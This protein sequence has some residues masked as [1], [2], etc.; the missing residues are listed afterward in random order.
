MGTTGKKTL[1]FAFILLTACS[2]LVP[3]PDALRLMCGF[4]QTFIL[5]GLVLLFFIGD[6]KRPWTD[7]IFFVPLLSPILITLTVYILSRLTGE[8]GASPGY[9]AGLF[10]IL[11]AVAVALKQDRYG[12]GGGTLPGGVIILSVCYG[13]LISLLFFANDILLIRS[14]AWY[15]ASVTGE[16][17]AR[18]IPPQEPYLA[19][20]PI[21][22]MWIYHLFTATLIK[23]TGL[24]LFRALSMLNI[25]SALSLPYLA[26]RV[27]SHFTV[28]RRVIFVSTLI[29][30]AGLESASWIA[31]PLCFLRA[32]NGDVRG[33]EEI[34]R[35]IHDISF[36]GS[37]TI[38]TLSPFGTWMVNLSDKYITITPF[39]FSLDL[40]LL[41]FVM[42]LSGNYVTD[43]KLKSGVMFFIIALGAFLFHVITGAALICTIIGAGV[44]LPLI[45]KF[46][47]G[48]AGSVSAGSSVSSSAH[49]FAGLPAAVAALAAGLVGLPYFLSLQ[50]SGEN[51]AMSGILHF[52]FKNIATILLPLLILYCPAKRALKK[53]VSARIDAYAVIAAWF[54]PLLLLNIFANLPTRNESKLIYPLFLLIG[55]VVSIEIVALISESQRRKR[56]LL[57]AWTLLLFFIPPFLTF[58]G[59]LIARPQHLE[60]L[61]VRYAA[62]KS[63]KALYRWIEENTG[64]DAVVS[65]NGFDHL[66][67]AFAARRNFAG[68]MSHWRIYGYDKEYISKYFDLNTELYTCRPLT[69]ETAA[70]IRATGHDL[71]VCVYEN[72]LKECPALTAKFGDRPDLFELV[73]S[74][75]HALLYHLKPA[76]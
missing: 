59:Y 76:G 67:P 55:S 14:D 71:Y 23:L 1:F 64:T 47:S 74:D 15:H 9:A 61:D 37:G 73:Y 4:V 39:S 65:E 42:A 57:I 2:L 16:I 41:G 60:F 21:Q 68:P 53:V 20:Q 7:T 58:R 52:G 38:R 56:F 25:V 75:A 22:Y 31:W 69:D 46:R 5:P 54:I 66:M 34:M 45:K 43:S 44:M 29:T 24:P 12:E 49:S 10:Y 62:Y 63:D 18:G 35:N 28:N 72:D 13:L 48:A 8:F 40:F 11:F 32:L 50:G 3:L 17:F 70:A 19:G 6:R 30:I 27:I 51:E 33:F 36:I 26:A